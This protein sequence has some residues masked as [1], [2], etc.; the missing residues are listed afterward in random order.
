MTRVVRHVEV[1]YPK[2]TDLAWACCHCTEFFINR[3]PRAAVIAHTW[4]KSVLSLSWK[5]YL[6]ADGTCRHGISKPLVDRDFFYHRTKGSLEKMRPSAIVN[7]EADAGHRC[8]KCK[9]E[10]SLRARFKR[11]LMNHLVYGCVLSLRS[12]TWG[13]HY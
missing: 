1:M 11:D 3:V 10:Y 13:I 8:L 2:P 12:R 7:L 4:A 5:G 9:E 6:L